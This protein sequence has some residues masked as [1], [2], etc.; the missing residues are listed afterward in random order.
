MWALAEWELCPAE[1]KRTCAGKQKQGADRQTVCP[2]RRP[3][4]KQLVAREK[5]TRLGHSGGI[6][7]ARHDVGGTSGYGATL[8]V[9]QFEARPRTSASV[10]GALPVPS[11]WSEID[12]TLLKMN[13]NRELVPGQKKTRRSK[14]ASDI[15]NKTELGSGWGL[16]SV[17]NRP[18]RAHGGGGGLVSSPLDEPTE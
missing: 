11:Y 10:Q 5:D 7:T 18:L 15:A 1:N 6:R 9:R 16:V 8:H 13:I 2:P 3:N 17:R 4:A 14:I 12:K